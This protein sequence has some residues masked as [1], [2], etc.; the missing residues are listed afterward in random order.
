MWGGENVQVEGLGSEKP[1]DTAGLLLGWSIDFPSLNGKMNI[2]RKS[3]IPVYF[4]R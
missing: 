3:R 4:L 1:N 2:Q